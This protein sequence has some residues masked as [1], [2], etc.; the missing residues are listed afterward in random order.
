MKPTQI[1]IVS[2]E[3]LFIKWDDSEEQT[4]TLQLIRR[5]C[6]CATCMAEKE[7]ESPTYIPLYISDQLKVENISVVGSYAISFAWKDGHN[8]GIYEFPYLK[9]LSANY[10]P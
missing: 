2:G 4:I 3:K 6:P 9:R 5:F 10:K 8:T 1:K 7:K